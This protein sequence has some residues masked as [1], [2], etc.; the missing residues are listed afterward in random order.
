MRSLPESF[1]R[2]RGTEEVARSL[3]G[4]LLVHETP[5]GL[6]SGRIVETEAYLGAVDPAA[7]TYRG[8]TK[9]NQ[10]MFGPPGCAYVYISYGM[11]YC[12]NTVCQET[13]TGEGVLI[14]A[15]EPVDG[16][17][18]MRKRRGHVQDHNL[19]NGPG[20]LCQA[21]GISLD[22]NGHPLQTSPLYILDAEPVPQVVTALRVGIRVG[23]D[24][25]LRFYV[26]DSPWVSRK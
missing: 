3:L 14:R 10:A 18:L 2:G 23:V 1:Y 21:L 5:E 26:A 8:P 17:E 24:L 25:P 22:V 6:V 11:H 9:R 16:L 15:L 13:G 4:K 7:H 20:K 19:A 12:F